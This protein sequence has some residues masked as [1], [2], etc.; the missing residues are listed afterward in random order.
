M[1]KVRF[2]LILLLILLPLSVTAM[3]TVASVHAADVQQGEQCGVSADKTVS[4]N[5]YT[6][7]Q[8]LTIDGVIHGDVVALAAYFVTGPVVARGAGATDARVVGPGHFDG[9]RE[10]RGAVFARPFPRKPAT[11]RA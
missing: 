6:L 7:C 1:F 5:L 4:G 10:I 3:T 8:T 9:S 11:F 2:I